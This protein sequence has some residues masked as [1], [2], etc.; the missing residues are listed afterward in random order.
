[1]EP[2]ALSLQ[3]LWDFSIA[4]ATDARSRWVLTAIKSNGPGLARMLWRIL[5]N[6]QDVCDAYQEI[7]IKLAA[8]ALENRPTKVRN[9][10]YRTGANTAISFLRKR[11]RREAAIAQAGQHLNAEGQSGPGEFYG[12]ETTDLLRRK[13][14]LLPD[15]LRE[16]ILLRDFAE[17]SYKQIGCALGITPAT[18]RVYRCKALNLLAVWFNNE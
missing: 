13:I 11:K 4:E 8:L 14:M 9:Y 15:S 10:L 7:F 6:E 3:H 12:E 1:M 18:A 2:K 5:G 16:V 17:M